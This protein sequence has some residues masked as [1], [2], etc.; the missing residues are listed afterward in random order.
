MKRIFEFACENGSNGFQILPKLM[1]FIGG[2]GGGGAGGS[3]TGSLTDIGGK[4]GKGAY[5]CG[6]GGGGGALLAQLEAE[7]GMV[8]MVWLS[9]LLGN[10]IAS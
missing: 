7:A 9:L 8:V 4:G 5:G 3:A 1:M 10:L 6:G 2:S